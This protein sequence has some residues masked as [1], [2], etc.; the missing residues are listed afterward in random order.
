VINALDYAGR[1]RFSTQLEYVPA[2]TEFDLVDLQPGRRLDSQQDA[3]FI[4]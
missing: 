2:L 1:G 3:K 4:V